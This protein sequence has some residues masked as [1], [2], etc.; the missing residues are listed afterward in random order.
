[1]AKET[2]EQKL[3]R[4]IEQ[5]DTAPSEASGQKNS[6]EVQEVLSAVQS[7]SGS[8]AFPAAFQNVIGFL[9]NF[10][11]HPSREY[12][13]VRA[14]NK[15]LIVAAAFFCLTFI[16]SI[17][18]GIRAADRPVEFDRPESILFSSDQ[19]LPIIPELQKYISVFSFRNIFHPYEK[20]EVVEKK[21]DLPRLPQQLSEKT[22]SLKLVGISWLDTPESASAMVEN[23]GNGITYFLYSGEKVNGVTVKT[24]YAD[25]V[26]L[27]LNGDQMELKL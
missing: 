3:L 27:E 11:A 2:A 15:I 18:R 8:V 20:K 21:G 19:L 17:A 1:M 7:V 25:S 10:L 23:T 12:F 14:I 4:L 16:I 22:K 6:S 9:K 26:L 24:I 5:N 13:G